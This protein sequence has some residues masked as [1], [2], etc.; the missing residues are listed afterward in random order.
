VQLTDEVRD[1]ISKEI[2]P[3]LCLDKKK[4]KELDLSQNQINT[5]VKN[6]KF[7]FASSGTVLK[8]DDINPSVRK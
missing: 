4:I 7:M 1:K 3:R 2:K 6:F 5:L 8:L